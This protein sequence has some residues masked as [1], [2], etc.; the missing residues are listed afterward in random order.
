MMTGNKGGGDIELCDTMHGVTSIILRR[1]SQVGSTHLMVSLTPADAPTH[2]LPGHAGVG[3]GVV[4]LLTNV[5]AVFVGVITLRPHLG[6]TGRGLGQLLTFTA[7]S[8]TILV[9]DAGLPRLKAAVLITGSHM[10]VVSVRSA[11]T[12]ANQPDALIPAHD[13]PRVR[14]GVGVGGALTRPNSSQHQQWDY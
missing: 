13:P 4:G 8:K 7:M 12:A 6:V 3:A 5:L 9:C 11:V 10:E 14:A 2:L 1:T